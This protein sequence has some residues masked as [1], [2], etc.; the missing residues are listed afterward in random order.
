MACRI[1]DYGLIGDCETSA[2][3]GKDGS[4][5]WLCWPTFSSGACFAA[6]L[7]SPENGRWQISPATE[8]VKVSRRYR[9]HT[10]ILETLFEAKDGRFTLIDFMPVRG[11]HSDV[12][13][14]VRGV[15]G[16]VAVRM[17]LA[18][19]FDYGRVVPWV[20]RC[21]DGL[22]AIAGPDMT[23]LRTSA[24][25][26][27]E[28]MKTVSEFELKEGEDVTFVLTYGASHEPRPR[29][30]DP[31]KALEDTEHTWLKWTQ[32]GKTAGPYSEAIE[33]SLITLKALTYK[34]T[35]G[36]VAAV[37]TSLPEA[38]GGNRNW[39]YRYC[40]LRDATFTLLA[41][42]NGGYYEE[43]TAWKNWLRRAI[44]GSPEQLQIMYGIS[45]ERNLLEW[46][47]TWLPGYEQSAPV[48]MGNAASNQVQLDV[49][50]EVMDAYLHA[51]LGI[52]DGDPESFKL[53]QNMVEHLE[54][55]WDQPDQ[56]IWESRGG[57][58]QFTYSKV[59]A[60]VAFD[61]AIRAAEHFGYSDPIARWTELRDRIHAE[62]C[63]KAFDNELGSF[64]QTYGSKMLDA[65]L[66]LMP[67]VGFLPN[68]DPRIKGTIEAIEKHL[69]SDG[70]VL[71]YD[72]SKV[73]D[74]LPPGEGVFLACSFW[75]VNALKR[76]G[77]EED[78]RKLFEHLLS[79]RNDLGLLSEEYD[80]TQKRQVG[81]FPQA[82]S[83]IALVNAAFSLQGDGNLRHRAPRNKESS[84]RRASKQ[85]A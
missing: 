75:M 54:T 11:K 71:R 63:A 28:D 42:M 9:P 51:E 69:V 79:L 48:R 67:L 44:A 47:A 7:G 12:V 8:I 6:L 56:G 59:M 27:G 62:V 13:R 5:D 80:T 49:Y 25:L 41:L 66:L 46:E 19:R 55:I 76:I 16:A 2:L 3:V 4:I 68:E 77:R 1:E 37:T 61:R 43:A 35:G 70:L 20:T 22:Q 50:G 78:A 34:P 33:R 10:L 30:I 21:E 17:E 14:I 85:Q 72:T 40:W 18:M 64:V 74:G 26:H 45:G 32:R 83:H 73:D 38:L 52:E 60:W 15:Q 29:A 57:P 65:S 31:H 82:L 24:E 36:I 53:P 39:D 58:Q 84:S 23:V 81:N